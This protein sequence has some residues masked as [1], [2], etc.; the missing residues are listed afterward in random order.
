[1]A[2]E[3]PESKQQK[4]EKFLNKAQRTVCW[5]AKDEFWDCMKVS[6][7]AKRPEIVSQY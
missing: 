7:V 4:G 2:E 3:E 6:K 5:K 1:M